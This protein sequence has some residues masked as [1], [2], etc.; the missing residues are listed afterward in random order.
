LI[1]KALCENYAAT[2]SVFADLRVETETEA[3]EITGF[4]EAFAASLDAQ[5][6][7]LLQNWWIGLR[8]RIFLIL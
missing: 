4:L 3:E 7:R 8:P 2:N 5:K 1:Q 6:F